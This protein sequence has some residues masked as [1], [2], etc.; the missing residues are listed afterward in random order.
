MLYKILMSG[1]QGMIGHLE[2]VF[3]IPNEVFDIIQIEGTEIYISQ[4]SPIRMSEGVW[5]Q[6]I[7][8]QEVINSDSLGHKMCEEVAVH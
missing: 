5:T 3:D 2:V 7:I 4:G 8:V 6:R 1:K